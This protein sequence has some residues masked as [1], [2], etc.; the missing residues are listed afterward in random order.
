MPHKPQQ[1]ATAPC[2]CAALTQLRVCPGE[3]VEVNTN[4]NDDPAL[5]NS[6]AEGDGWM[7]KVQP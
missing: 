6:S 4:L 1:H 5:V 2:D 7:T 3:V